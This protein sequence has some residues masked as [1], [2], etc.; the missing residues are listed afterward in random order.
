MS[1]ST[2]DEWADFMPDT[3]T[4]DAWVGKTVSDAPIYAL[5]PATFQ[6]RVEIKNHMI[7]DNK[8]NEIVARGRVFMRTTVIP[9]TR[10]KLVL[11]GRF[12]PVSPPIL[13]VN[14]VSDESGT[15][16]VTLEIG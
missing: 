16:H 1:F 7:R 5:A 9:D 2:V 3:V 13:A 12:E 6:A 4:L 10:D 14:P 8:G 15:H 11:P